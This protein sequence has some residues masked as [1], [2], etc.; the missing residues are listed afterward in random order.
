MEK[1][2]DQW[3]DGDADVGRKIR[4]ATL[5]DEEIGRL[6]EKLKSLLG[7]FAEHKLV[8]GELHPF[9]RDQKVQDEYDHTVLL[10]EKRHAE[11]KGLFS[12]KDN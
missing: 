2:E 1:F 12:V 10:I 6:R 7:K 11:I 5:N 4:E 9:F 8:E 3:Q